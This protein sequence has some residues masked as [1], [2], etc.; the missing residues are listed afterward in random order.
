MP[1]SLAFLQMLLRLSLF[2]LA[3]LIS[4]MFIFAA[5]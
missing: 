4:N 3:L 1:G 2:D 5:L